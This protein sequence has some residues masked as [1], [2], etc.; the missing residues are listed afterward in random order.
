MIHSGKESMQLLLRR[1]RDHVSSSW[2]GK[3]DA[4]EV[5]VAKTLLPN[6]Q[7]LSAA[8]LAAKNVGNLWAE[9]QATHASFMYVFSLLISNKQFKI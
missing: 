7:T 3:R 2:E 9:K 8:A 5:N 1:F 4:K 6:D